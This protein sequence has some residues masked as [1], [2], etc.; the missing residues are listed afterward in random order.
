[1]R[2]PPAGWPRI[3]AELVYADAPGAIDWLIRAFDFQRV[4]QV[5]GDAGAIVHAELAYAGGLVLVIGEDA[6]GGRRRAPPSVGGK[7]TQ[8][9]FVYVPDVEA[10][11]ARAAAAGAVIVSPLAV[12]DYGDDYWA[13]RGYECRDPGGHHWWFAE[14]LREGAGYRPLLDSAAL[15]PAPPP[16]GWPRMSSSLLYADAAAAI[17]WLASALDFQVQL[18]VEG[19]GGR[20]EHAELVYGGGL[21]MVSDASHAGHG[22]ARFPYRAV[23][24]TLAGAN[25]QS[26][27]VYVDDVDAHHARAAAAGATI[28]RAPQVNDHGEGY[29]ADRSYGLVDPGGHAW[30]CCQRVRG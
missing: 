21:V 12:S 13:D 30:W 19:E 11:C 14:R 16:K 9:L 10:H 15:G 7:N 18:R 20:I 6:A 8:N 24:A 25:T 29:W 26:L 27:T 1:M 5:T 4:L 17:D 23:P 28:L 3:T 2:P 22:A